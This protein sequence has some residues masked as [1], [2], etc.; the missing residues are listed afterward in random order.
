MYDE[1]RYRE[2]QK[3]EK[4]EKGRRGRAKSFFYATRHRDAKTSHFQAKELE[5]SCGFLTF[6]PPRYFAFF[7]SHL[8]T[9]ICESPC[10]LSLPD[11][12]FALLIFLV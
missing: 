12:L 10:P 7:N 8:L 2:Y 4:G 11:Q 9:P 6:S 3:A 1:K 5:K